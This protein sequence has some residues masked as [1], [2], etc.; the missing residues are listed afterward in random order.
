MGDQAARTW[1]LMIAFAPASGRVTRERLSSG[2]PVYHSEAVGKNQ[3]DDPVLKVR[4][5]PGQKGRQ[6]HLQFERSRPVLGQFARGNGKWKK[7]DADLAGEIATLLANTQRLDP[8]PA[9]LRGYSQAPYPGAV[10]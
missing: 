3:P 8:T 7:S 4:Y 1:E 9:I 2:G 5:Y 10:W 6:P